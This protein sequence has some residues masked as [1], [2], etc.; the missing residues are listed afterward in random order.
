MRKI[1]TTDGSSRHHGVTFG[2]LDAGFLFCLQQIKQCAFLGMIRTGRI[3]SRRSNTLILLLD[4]LRVTEGFITGIAPEFFT[5]PLM[6]GFGKGF[7]KTV[8]Q[9]QQ[10]D[11]PV[12]IVF[13]LVF[14]CHGFDFLTGRDGKAADPVWL[15]T[16][17]RRNEIGQGII[18]FAFAALFELLTQTMQYR[19]YFLA[20]IIGI[21]LDVITNCVY[22]P[23]TYDA[24]R[25]DQFLLDQL[26]E[27]FLSIFIKVAGAL[28]NHFIIKNFRKLAGQLP[29]HEKR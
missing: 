23:E 12:I 18:G 28:S 10:H 2:E 22:R 27:H 3:T 9:C 25:G 17:F 15:A 21:Q 14:F 26:F 20:F 24:F 13:L 6:H 4:Q 8:S 7:G 11:G 16:V 19:L 29:A 5:H 1:Q